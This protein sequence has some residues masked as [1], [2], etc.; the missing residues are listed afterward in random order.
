MLA[1]INL[2]RTNSFDRRRHRPMCDIM[3]CFTMA[4]D[5]RPV[6]FYVILSLQNRLTKMGKCGKTMTWT[7]G[8]L[9]LDLGAKL[10]RTDNAY[11]TM[12]HSY[13]YGKY[14]SF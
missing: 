7:N 13:K 6:F 2:S 1:S 8:S 3:C 4:F 11:Q 14:N 10:I 12:L 9:S 5:E